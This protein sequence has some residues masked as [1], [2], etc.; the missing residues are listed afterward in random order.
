MRLFSPSFS[1][2]DLLS[3]SLYC[4][5]LLTLHFAVFIYKICVF[6]FWLV[7]SNIIY[8]CC[9]FASARFS[10]AILLHF[11]QQCDSIRNALT[12]YG[13]N[14]YHPLPYLS[15][16][17]SRDIQKSTDSPCFSVSLSPLFS[18]SL[19]HSPCPCPCPSPI[20]SPCPPRIPLP[21][22]CPRGF[23]RLPRRR[24][25]RPPIPDEAP[26]PHVRDDGAP[27]RLL[28]EAFRPVQREGRLR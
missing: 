24:C 21:N 1:R 19:S 28:Q 20:L 25:A 10:L 5:Y 17:S 22:R 13:M 8:Q 23:R 3:A 27:R 9:N 2:A 26:R 7:L 12:L 16:C 15:Y 14:I 6:G 11:L 18:L 4:F